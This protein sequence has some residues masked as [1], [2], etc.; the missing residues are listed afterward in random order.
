MIDMASR[1][2]SACEQESAGLGLMPFMERLR[3]RRTFYR[4]VLEQFL[5]P[6][7]GQR[8]VENTPDK[9]IPSL[10]RQA[11]HEGNPGSAVCPELVEGLSQDTI[12]AKG[13]AANLA[14]AE[15]SL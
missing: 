15:I 13:M 5:F 6:S 11:R 1:L 12:W 10:V 2:H 7:D 8:G 3:E 9:S 14:A 4:D